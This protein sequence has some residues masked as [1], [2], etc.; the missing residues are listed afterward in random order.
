MSN[1]VIGLTGGIGSGKTT[2]ANLF[3]DLGIELIDADII[4]REVVENGTPAFKEIVNYFGPDVLTSNKELD[5][6]KLRSKVF[7]NNQA[8]EWLNN[9]LHPLIRKTMFERVQSSRSPYCILVVPLLIEGGMHT[10]VDRVLV[11]DLPEDIQLIRAS[12]R[13]ENTEN[14]IK[15]IM[16]NQA[17]RAQRLALADD[18]IDNESEDLSAPLRQ[19]NALHLSYL[20]LADKQ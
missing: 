4:A 11:I 10:L 15:R 13:D 1:F 18:I 3:A 19:V 6:V 9:L 5:R 17:T 20:K 7:K 16:S 14:E 12:A 8:R 2:I